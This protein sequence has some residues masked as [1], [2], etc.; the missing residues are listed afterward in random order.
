M[1]RTKRDLLMSSEKIIEETTQM[2]V[3]D[4]GIGYGTSSN[5]CKRG[6]IRRVTNECAAGTTSS[7]TLLHLLGVTERVCACSEYKFVNSWS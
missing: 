5:D 2:R 1:L 6:Q 3:M 4:W 7:H